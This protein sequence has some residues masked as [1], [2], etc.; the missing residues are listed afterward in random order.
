MVINTG[1][2]EEKRKMSIDLSTPIAMRLTL[3]Y[4]LY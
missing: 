2:G 4:D 1:T 3:G